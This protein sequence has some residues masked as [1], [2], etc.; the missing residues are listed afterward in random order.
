MDG[1]T[2]YSIGDL[3]RRTGLSVRTIRFYADA[4][5][6]PPTRRSP[7]GYRL[8]DLDALVRLELVRTLRDLGID[9]VTIRRVL[10]REVTVAEVAEAHAN[11]V[12]T[13]IRT[14]RLRRAVLRAVARR[15]SS[16]EELD[17]MHK[18]A[19]LSDEERRKMITDFLDATFADLDVDPDFLAKMRCGL[20]A[21]PDDPTAE[22]VE[23]WVELGELVADPDFRASIRRMAEYQARTRGDDVAP[24]THERLTTITREWVEA[25]R[26]AG[27]EPTSPEAEPVLADLLAEYAAAFG[28][29]PDD[30]FV[31]WLSERF[32]VG[33]DPRAER[34]WQLLGV[35]NGW[36]S[37]PSLAPV[38][39][40]FLAA[41]R[42]RA[43]NR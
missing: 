27:I 29:T 38:F 42:A 13:Q 12:D 4:G 40:W 25:A 21:L 22:Q 28:R 31:A 26:T 33:T 15:A 9:L 3:A 8:Y 2:L 35:M 32:E 17:L 10:A 7:A 23:A 14:L 6:V 16:P 1:A 36:P 43:R 20:P 37:W 39:D 5:V 24:G 11:A 34:Y 18:L 19:K 41:L 30:A